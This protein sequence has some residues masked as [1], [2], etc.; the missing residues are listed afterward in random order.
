[1]SDKRQKIQLELALTMREQSEA[2]RTGGQGTET[3]AATRGTDSPANIE[4]L[5]EDPEEV[6]S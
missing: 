2:L 3:L 6:G 4:R 5:M 1:M